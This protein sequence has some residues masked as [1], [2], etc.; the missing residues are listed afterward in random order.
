[1]ED[2]PV[3]VWDLAMDSPAEIFILRAHT[4]PIWSVTYS[5][6]GEHLASGS[7]DT[8]VRIWDA[9]TGKEKLVLRGHSSPILGLA[10]SGD[11]KQLASG[12]GDWATPGA[13]EVKVWDVR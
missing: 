8:T 11:G 7:D 12:S 6:D 5:A 1:G 3:R 13:G 2:M 9:R 10:F 4:R